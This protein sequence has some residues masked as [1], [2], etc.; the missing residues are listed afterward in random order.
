[1]MHVEQIPP[2]TVPGF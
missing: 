2:E 1:M